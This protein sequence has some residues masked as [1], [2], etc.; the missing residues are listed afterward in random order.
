MRQ[1]E[2]QKETKRDRESDRQRE[3]KRERESMCFSYTQ[4]VS[5][6]SIEKT[7]PKG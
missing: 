2:R 5:M 7:N 6:L 1:R 4:R 3:T